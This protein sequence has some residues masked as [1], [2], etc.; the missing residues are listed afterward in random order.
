MARQIN[1]IG[2]LAFVLLL[3]ILPSTAASHNG[4]VALAYPI[5]GI[6]IDGNLDDWPDDMRRYPI[7]FVEYGDPIKNAGDFEGWFRIGYSTSQNALYVA[8]E[9]RD[10]SAV[11]EPSFPSNW[12]K[13]DGCNVY[14]N[15]LHVEKDSTVDQ[16]ITYGYHRTTRVSKQAVQ[17]EWKR[18]D[19]L[20]RYEWRLNVDKIGGN[21]IGL[22]A[23]MTIGWDIAICDKDGDGSFS[24]VS[25]GKG[26]D[27]RS[28]KEKC[29]TVVLTAAGQ[30]TGWLKGQVTWQNTL[31]KMAGENVKVSSLESD[32]LWVRTKTDKNGAYRIEL[33]QGSYE[34]QAG[35]D[36]RKSAKKAVEIRSSEQARADLDILGA[37]GW[38]VTAGPGKSI[39]AVGGLMED[40][41]H[42]RN[43]YG[44]TNVAVRA[45]VQS[46]DSF[47]W[48]ATNQGL[49]RYD[50]EMFTCFSTEDG[51][52]NNDVHALMVDR[53]GQLWIGTSGGMCVYNG[54]TFTHFTVEDG[55]IDNAVNSL[56]EDSSGQLWIGTPRGASVYDGKTFTHFTTE[57]GLRFDH[58]MAL[59]EDSSG[60]IWLGTSHAG[61]SVYDG[62]AFTHFTSESE[63][64]LISNRVSALLEDSSGRIWIGTIGGGVSLYDGADFT[65][66]ATEDGLADNNVLAL[67]EDSAGR[68]WI[69]GWGGK[70]SLYDQGKFAIKDTLSYAVELAFFEDREGNF[71]W[72][73]DNGLIRYDNT[74]TTPITANAL[75]SH[76][77]RTL[78]ED[79]K[80]RIW[81]G[82]PS[83]VCV[84]DGKTVTS[85]TEE[86]GFVGNNIH[87]IL[88]DST[89]RIWIG[90]QYNGV[91]VFDGNNFTTYDTKNG[92]I[93]SQVRTLMEY[94][95]GRVWIGTDIGVSVYDGGQF[96]YFTIEDGLVDNDVRTLLKDRT[97]R[98]WIGTTFGISVYDRESVTS[99]TKEDGLVSNNVH[100]L[101]EDSSGC[102]WIGTRDAGVSV[103]DGENFTN[104]TKENGLASN[105]V[106]TLL[107][108]K[109]GH[110]WIG[111]WG[112]GVSRYDGTSFQSLTHEDGLPSAD[113]VALIEDKQGDVWIGTVAGIVR[114]HRPR[115]SHP[116]VQLVDVVTDRRCGAVN[117]IRLP[118]TQSLL[119]F[120][121]QGLSFKTRPGGM[122]YRYRLKGYQTQ[123]QTTNSQRVEYNNLP[124]GDYT[125]EL[126]AIDRDLSYSETPVHVAVA[127]HLPYKLIAFWSAVT[128]AL[129]LGFWEIIRVSQRGRRLRAAHDELELRIEERTS[130]LSMSNAKL[131]EEV[132]QRKQQEKL[133][134]IQCD[135]AVQL[136]ATA[137]LEEGL[138]ICLDAAIEASEM[139][140]GGIYLVDEDSGALELAAHK[141]LSTEFVTSI[142]HYDVNSDNLKLIMKGEAV[143]AEHKQLDVLLNQTQK[144]EDLRAIA[145]V[146]VLNKDQIIGC[147]NIAS[148]IFDHINPQSRLAIESIAAQIGSA[149]G[150]LRVEDELR[151]SEE[152]YHTLFS[153]T[154]EGVALHELIYDESG[155]PTDY[156]ILDVN[157]AYESILGIRR[158]EAVG[159][160]ASDLYGID[161]VPYL[162][163]YSAVAVSGESFSF[164]TYY[165]TMDKHFKISAF[166]PTKGKFANLFADITERKQAQVAL[167]TSKEFAENIIETANAIVVVLD[168]DGNINTFNKFAEELTG[169]NK[170]EVLGKNWFDLFITEEE[171]KA[172]REVKEK[173]HQ[174]SP[175]TS[176]YEN[177][178]I[179]K[180][181]E[182]RLIQ[183]NNHSF[184]DNKGTI[185]G[186]I[187]IG[188]D[189]TEQ[190]M[191]QEEL[192]NSREEIRNQNEF[193]N[194][195][196]ESLTHP[197]LVLDANNY[198]VKIANAAARAGRLSEGMSCYMLSHKL[199]QPCH[200]LGCSCPLKDIKE[201]GHAMTMEHIHKDRNDNPQYVEVHSSPI[202]D[203]KG[204]VTD[205]IEY[206][207]DVTKRKL[208]EEKLIAYQAQLRSLASDLSLAEE[209]ERRHI[210]AELHDQISQTL[211]LSKM[212]LQTLGKSAGLADNSMFHEV[213]ESIKS[214]IE[215]VQH[216][217]FDL[218]SP[219]LYKFGLE[220]AVDELLHDQL[221]KKG[222][223]Y[224]LTD[225]KLLKPLDEEVMVL[226]FQSV[227]ELLI[228]IIKHAQAHKVAVTIQ[229]DG[230]NIL[231]TVGDD[232]VGFDAD[233]LD[234]YARLAGRTG[235][236]GLFN[237]R[238]RL[239]YISGSF[240]IE[241]QSGKGSRFT[242]KAPLKVEAD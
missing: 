23:G 27:K 127:V 104:F 98:V 67:L 157:P 180:N 97:G 231:I 155:K 59:L 210:A 192:K 105:N 147:L 228:N 189:I 123:W 53:L 170:K 188:I 206:C 56:L 216:L 164:E 135:L 209:R 73:T 85:F 15:S 14:I 234:S 44:L 40:K 160:K 35:Q 16:F 196:L 18:Q 89:G 152:R 115:H 80:G 116:V 177:Y 57:N 132:V 130:E 235:G 211:A 60:R 49:A 138:S 198:K 92:L 121:Y 175:E 145:V 140:C 129:V 238:E 71:W 154:N 13:T 142:A 108:D 39:K 232:G 223:T 6:I 134:G 167:E 55:L 36:R 201:F 62:E 222:L 183:W 11:Q 112:G 8:V 19:D 110:I 50:G 22:K 9:V 37:R 100:V 236:F 178:I 122:V 30:S 25:W 149:A 215:Q 117:Q 101:L 46:D 81:I 51:L 5:D 171:E 137:K 28:S 224:K 193:L 233:R 212:N 75:L 191:A 99:I 78:L 20:Y 187:S 239:N 29:G 213:V 168:P 26:A 190:K 58:I 96:S 143:Y 47:L 21:S 111:T 226:L 90:T 174:D 229:R 94:S 82:N 194:N 38:T 139:D 156:R 114:H 77:V 41:F 42:L 227:R 48:L 65:N 63:D 2:L 43:P 151:E 107:E 242:L 150:R 169:Y 144:N 7:T 86:D 176:S 31:P 218:S 214:T 120:E 93:G 199:G 61:V 45:I 153:A 109:I 118:S 221:H 208:A 162:G 184:Q 136:S 124:R 230:D 141:E 64:G 33:P 103:Y 163:I 181:A 166:S 125:F 34:V 66:F 182:K 95:T 195:V 148:H 52:P 202:L 3:M 70:L 161:E 225:D 106:R 12:Q 24:W 1:N 186:N 185:I 131:I 207:I 83:G 158:E 84:Y 241:S 10:E 128:V 4:A 87:S 197:F 146:P 68:V 113:V 102:I 179:T 165:E 204:N 200:E 17:W 217:T 69:G 119:A 88:E 203:D 76:N 159:A 219:T 79:S 205:I 72:G 173:V 220:K 172:I 237:I 91:S 240:E 74:L 54:E 133:T 32:D 126:Q